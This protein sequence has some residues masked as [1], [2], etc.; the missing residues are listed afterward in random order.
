MEA[1]KRRWQY[2][3]QEIKAYKW[4]RQQS[5]SSSNEKQLLSPYTARN[6][7]AILRGLP[8]LSLRQYLPYWPLARAKSVS[9]A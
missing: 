6:E 7:D 1:A 8:C 4:S 2:N 9:M 3:I 5:I